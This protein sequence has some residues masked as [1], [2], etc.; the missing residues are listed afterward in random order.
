MFQLFR[1]AAYK[2]LRFGAGFLIISLV[3]GLAWV[4]ACASQGNGGPDA[5]KTGDVYGGLGLASD[6]VPFMAG[7]RAGTLPNGLRYFILE[8]ARPE[9]RAFMTLAVNAGSVLETEQERG[10]A[11][12]TEHMAFN[13]TK[14]FP[15]Q[16]LVDYLRSLGMRFGA[17]LNAYTS[18]DETVYS[19]EA[20]VETG[21]DGIKR[22]PA[23]ALAVLDDW[24]YAVSFRPEDVE[25]ERAVILE[26]YRSR[27]GAAERVMQKLL[28][29][30]FRGSPYAERV[31]IG[32]IEV[33]RSA[34]ASALEN[35][36]KKWYR[37][38]NMALVL[39]G[40]FDGAALERELAAHFTAPAPPAPLNR[41]FYELPLP[42]KNSLRIEILSD[43]EYP[44]PRVDIY[45]RE[46]PRALRGDLESFRQGLIDALIAQMVSLRMEEAASKPEAPFAAAGSWESR[47]GRESRFY[48]M[49]A[50][51]KSGLTRESLKAL[52]REKE[53]ISRY[54][55]TAAEIDRAKR[56]LISNFM[57]QASEKDKQASNLFTSSFVSHFLENQNAADIEWELDAAVRMLPLISSG[58]IGA[59]AKNYFSFN[60]ATL[61]L[62]APDS[63]ADALP[64][65]AELKRILA[66]S[67]RE[68]I[69]RPKETPISDK[70]LDKEPEPGMIASE[71]L[72]ADSGA[73]IWELGNGARVILKETA[74]KNNEIILYAIARG[75]TTNA[76]A[77][78][79]VSVSLAAEMMNVS[80]AGPYSRTELL[81]KL[82]DKQ[83]SLA[84]W[85][86]LFHRGFE[87]RAASGDLKTLFDLLYLNFTQ[88]RL[89][90][91]AVEAMLDQYRT[92]L[93]KKDEDPEEVFS[94]EVSRAAFGNNRFSRPLALA[95]IENARPGAALDFMRRG[96]GPQDYTFVFTGNL[97][98]PVVRAYVESRLAAIPRTE[99]GM[100]AF[101][102]PGIER[103]G[104]IE[105]AVYKGKE[106]K[107]LVFMG[108]FLPE[109]YDE[110]L[111]AAALALT[112][113]LDIILT[114]EIREKLG[115][116]YYVSAGVSLSSLPEDGE[117]TMSS[118][119]SCDPKRAEEL[120][121]AVARQIELVA[122]GNI[123]GDV[124][125]KALEALKKSWELSMQDNSYIAKNY[126]SLAVTLKLPLSQLEKRP[127][128]YAAVTQAEIQDICRRLLPRG[129]ARIIL[130]PEGWKQVSWK[131]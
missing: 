64:D 29:I 13:G 116:V 90:S 109:K 97:D 46:A 23:K 21:D 63:E 50:I 89:D 8:N 112:E 67:R 113:Y 111:R 78:E 27:L 34:P 121:G 128:L 56:A 110:K 5:G 95:D 105:K 33:I 77:G 36:Y 99:E 16:E 98:I 129:P 91:G 1:L 120:S 75:G 76:E 100:N 126:G 47:Y 17:D 43:P 70:L 74:N 19:I 10:L 66:A 79:E 83:V 119:F 80:G 62:T 42:V 2:K 55:F 26:E 14:R 45:Y 18:F 48:V 86:A 71:S 106:E 6:P 38:D 60:D 11:H 72:D 125:A 61:F 22:I 130:Y 41:P 87:G 88:P 49:S 9:N 131:Q 118:Y 123:N 52:L 73:I 35:F 28:P 31:P 53:S 15:G 122:E 81:Q 117:L 108:W 20:P 25:D 85:T 12:F 92:I 24:S 65:A 94:D 44:Y 103:P 39:V 115:G 124:F 114:E 37:P 40:D 59:A 82:A 58:E 93:A 54:G 30:L 4:S 3:C 69:A 127:G 57:Q 84:W 107:S 68:R 32:L 102:D 51:A 101:T 96:L 104:K 7:A